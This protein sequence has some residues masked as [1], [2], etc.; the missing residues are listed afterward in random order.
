M[1]FARV[2]RCATPAIEL[3][4]RREEWRAG[5]L[6]GAVRAIHIEI[7]FAGGSANAHPPRVAAHLA[8]L[9]ERAVDVGLDVDFDLLAAV[10]AGHREPIVRL[11][12]H[13]PPP[14]ATYRFVRL[15]LVLSPAIR[16]RARHH[17]K[18]FDNR[19]RHTLVRFLRLRRP[20][21]NW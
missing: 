3:A 1:R 2:S 20:M 21:Q 10:R 15:A 19:P 11:V 17:A 9:D 13:A 7:S 16:S 8:V 18:S 12:R 6:L 5:E 4:S 14:L